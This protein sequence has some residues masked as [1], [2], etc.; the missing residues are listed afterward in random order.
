M[1]YRIIFYK[2]KWFDGHL[3]DN[4]IEVV[5]KIPNWNSPNASHVEVWLPDSNGSFYLNPFILTKYDANGFCW[6]GTMLTSTMRGDD[7]GTVMRP[8]SGILK[9]PKRW[10]YFELE[11]DEADFDI[12]MQW[13]VTAVGN[14]QGYGK[15]TLLKFIGIC[16][17]DKLRNIC[18][19]VAHKFA[20]LC[21]NMPQP[22]KTPSPRRLARWCEDM[23]LERH[24]L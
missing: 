22:P 5:T 11:C 23:G 14:N 19:Q 13:A 12:A 17:P 6:R 20:V 10:F 21:E 3:V 2:P 24:E 16:W 18:S 8:A 1:K 4:V 9:N 7:N 15:R